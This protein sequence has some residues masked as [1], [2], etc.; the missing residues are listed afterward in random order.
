[1]SQGIEGFFEYVNNMVEKEA[2]GMVQ[3]NKEL[4]AHLSKDELLDLQEVLRQYFLYLLQ[5]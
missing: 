5:I 1:M 2:L 3:A 4:K